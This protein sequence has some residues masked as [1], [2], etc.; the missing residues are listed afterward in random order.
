VLPTKGIFSTVAVTFS[1]WCRKG[2]ALSERPFALYHQQPEMGKQNVDFADQW[3]NFSEGLC[4][5][6]LC[7]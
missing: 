3:K 6:C 5:S 1:L 4:L 7:L 2:K